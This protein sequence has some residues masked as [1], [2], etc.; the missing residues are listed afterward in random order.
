MK[1][2]YFS[3]VFILLSMSLSGSV[4]SQFSGWKE[5]ALEVGASLGAKK[6]GLDE[7]LKKPAAITTS[8]DDVNKLGS[9]FA[10]QFVLKNIQPLYLLPKASA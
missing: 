10:D 4:Y 8:F 5:K 1:N 7:V 9:K 3:A 6:L 2:L